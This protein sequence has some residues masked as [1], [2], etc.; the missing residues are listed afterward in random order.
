MRYMKKVCVGCKHNESHE[1]GCQCKYY[2]QGFPII[3]CDCKMKST[4]FRND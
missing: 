4:E 2:P 3:T 1:G